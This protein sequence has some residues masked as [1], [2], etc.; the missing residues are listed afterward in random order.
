MKQ[1]HTG[2]S[3]VFAVRLTA[4]NQVVGSTRYM[5]IAAFDRQLEIGT[6]WYNSAVWGTKVN[7]ECKLLLMPHAF[8]KLGCYRVEYRCDAR[9]RR[10]RATI[11]KLG[12][13]E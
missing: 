12:A 6:T 13:T 5:N 10:S 11:L 1:Q 8:E 3:L 9:N 7:P 4:E 2:E